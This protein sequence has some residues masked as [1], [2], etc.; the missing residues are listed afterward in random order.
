V[1]PVAVTVLPVP[2][3][4]LANV[5]A[6]VAQLTVSPATTPLAVTVQLLTVA[7]VVPS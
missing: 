1:T 5:A 3:V 6:P 2:A 7:L 4:A